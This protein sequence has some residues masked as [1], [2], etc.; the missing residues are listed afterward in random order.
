MTTATMMPATAAPPSSFRIEPRESIAGTPWDGATGD[1]ALA[2]DSPSEASAELSF[3]FIFRLLE[4]VEWSPG[5]DGADAEHVARA[6]AQKAMETA[7]RTRG[8]APE[9][10]VA[11]APTGSLLLQWDFADGVSVEVYVDGEEDFPAWAAVALG[12]NIHEVE[13]SGLASLEALLRKYAA[14]AAV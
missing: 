10:F 5:W 11:P 8:I 12:G 9:P 3:E 14:D 1:G 4:F 13:L 2:T 7:R 6:T